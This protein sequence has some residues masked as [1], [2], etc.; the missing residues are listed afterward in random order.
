MIFKFR[1][2]AV[3]S[4][5]F[6]C[7]SCD[8]SLDEVYQ[9]FDQANR[10]QFL[11]SIK[12]IHDDVETEPQI[13]GFTYTENNT[14]E[15]FTIPESDQITMKYNKENGELTNFEEVADKIFYSDLIFKN[16]YEYEDIEM[17]FVSDNK[18]G[19][20]SLIKMYLIEDG[21]V[22]IVSA[23]ITYDQNPNIYKPY[24]MAGGIVEGADGKELYKGRG[25]YFKSKNLPKHN[26]LTIKYFNQSGEPEHIYFVEYEY[27]KKQLVTKS[28]VNYFNIEEGTSPEIT[29]VLYAYMK[30]VD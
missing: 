13:Y 1:V 3:L 5:I 6:T 28:V 21:D 26:P 14:L 24:L 15:S 22:K 27:N 16:P 17:Y 4:M 23:E 10:E 19:D 11:E 7:V 25:L 12:I 20:P 9:D 18:E 29:T 2:L 8:D 30:D